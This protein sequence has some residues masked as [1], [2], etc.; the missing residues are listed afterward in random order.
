MT[1]P[2]VYPATPHDRRH[3]PAGYADYESYRPWLRDEFAFRCVFCLTR[4][5]WGPFHAQF[6]I[7]HFIPTKALAAQPVLYE[8]LLYSCVTCNSIKGFRAIPDPLVTLLNSCVRV[9]SDGMMAASTAEA[10]RLIDD[11]ACRAFLSA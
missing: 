10:R 4:E 3:G 8:N 1:T 6:A 2:F 5:T 7:D 9:A 11:P